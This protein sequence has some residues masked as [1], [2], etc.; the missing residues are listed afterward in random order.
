MLGLLFSLVSCDTWWQQKENI[1]R[2]VYSHFSW[3]YCKCMMDLCFV[4][5][6]L[7]EPDV[8]YVYVS[9]CLHIICGKQK[10]EEE[11]SS[12]LKSKELYCS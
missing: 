5:I 6:S 7:L 10:S 11:F 4:G 3:R 2:I 1:F 12:C 9:M 8:Q